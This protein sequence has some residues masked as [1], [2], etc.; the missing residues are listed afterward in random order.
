MDGNLSERDENEDHKHSRVSASSG[1][2]NHFKASGD[3]GR[4]NIRGDGAVNEKERICGLTVIREESM[5]GESN[6]KISDAR[7]IKV[8]DQNLSMTENGEMKQ[9]NS[10]FY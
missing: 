10:S 3:I 1:N 8:R 6:L 4:S 5:I 2:D 9:K 7:L